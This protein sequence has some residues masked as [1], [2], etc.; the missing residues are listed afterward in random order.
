MLS[1]KDILTPVTEQEALDS[2][3]EM[4]DTVGF[5][6]TSWQSGSIAL[7]LVQVFARVQADFATAIAE[8]AKGA[9][10]R[11]AEGPWLDLVAQSF[12][13]N[14]RGGAVQT[15]GYFRLT[16]ASTAPTHVVGAN[17]AIFAD[18]DSGEANTYRNVS[19]F[20]LNPGDVIDVEVLAEVAGDEANIASNSTLYLWTTLAGVTV[21]NPTY[22]TNSSWITEFGAD[23][24]TDAALR[25]RNS[26]K[27]SVLAYSVTEGAYR[28]WV[29]NAIPGLVTRMSIRESLTVPGGVDIVCATSTGTITGGQAQTIEDYLNGTDGVGRR[30]LNDIVDVQPATL[31]TLPLY[32]VVTI[33]STFAGDIETNVYDIVNEYLGEL[34]IGGTVLP[35]SSQGVALI[36]TMI[37]RVKDLDGVIDVKFYSADPTTNDP[38]AENIA[39]SPGRVYTTTVP[40]TVVEVVV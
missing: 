12:Y 21:T 13:E 18:Q 37:S 2:M 17:E 30:P 8:I 40:T 27:L 35:G 34:P 16:A 4:L 6:A 7:T 23:E 39:L 15:R 5:N 29:L 14:T 9:F 22:L 3:L 26:T 25:E 11:T 20:T 28:H 1:L 10:N 31:D 33:E 32:C 38:I 24:E 19:G 36:S